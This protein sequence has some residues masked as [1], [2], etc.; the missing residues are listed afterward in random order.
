MIIYKAPRAITGATNLSK[1]SK[2][3]QL[4]AN[5]AVDKIFDVTQDV[6]GEI[7]T[8]EALCNIHNREL[9]RGIMRGEIMNGYGDFSPVANDHSLMSCSILTHA[10]VVAAQTRQPVFAPLSGFHHAHY[11]HSAGYCT[12]NGL[13]LAASAVKSMNPLANVL[14]VDGD[15][16]YGDGTQ[17]LIEHHGWNDWLEQ[18]SLD[19]SSTAGD[20]VRA[21]ERLKESLSKK[22]WDLVIYQAGADSH[23]DDPYGAGYLNDVDWKERDYTVFEHCKSHDTPLVF[24]LAG[25]YNGSKTVLLHLGTVSTAR[26]VYETGSPA[27]LSPEQDPLLAH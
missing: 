16:H 17:D 10:S 21:Q 23:K 22:A 5:L 3:F 26:E 27:H 9:V 18:C 19:R 8:L 24:N 14:I 6:Q 13:A 20:F 11:A 7:S 4:A 12:F 2:V 1:G 15:G 25:G